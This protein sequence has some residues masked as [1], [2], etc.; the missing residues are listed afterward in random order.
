MSAVILPPMHNDGSTALI[1]I[2]CVLTLDFT[3]HT[4][5]LLIAENAERRKTYPFVTCGR[6]LALLFLIK[7][8]MPS[9]VNTIGFVCAISAVRQSSTPQSSLR[10]R[11]ATLLLRDMPSELHCDLLFFVAARTHGRLAQVGFNQC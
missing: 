9:A 10:N 7:P 4:N 2:T 1:Y 8:A 6:R 5:V 3:V 11:T